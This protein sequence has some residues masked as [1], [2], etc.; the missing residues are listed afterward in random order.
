MGE[1]DMKKTKIIC[2]LGS[3]VDD[4]NLFL[5]L[6]EYMDVARFNF[7][8]GDYNEHLGRLKNLKKSEKKQVN[9]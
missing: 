5:K 7:S 9:K 6:S 8:H 2:T 1:N 3:N 4:Y